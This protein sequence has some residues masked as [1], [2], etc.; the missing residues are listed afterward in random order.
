[1][2]AADSGS[3]DGNS[4]VKIAVAL[5][6]MVVQK[7]VNA[8]RNQSNEKRTYGYKVNTDDGFTID[9]SAY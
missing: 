2:N 5:L 4:E 3:I 9:N 8:I 6:N 7:T 1:M